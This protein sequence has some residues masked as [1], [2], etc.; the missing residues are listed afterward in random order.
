MSAATPSKLINW[1]LV[2]WVLLDMDGT[3]LDLAYDNWFWREHV[4]AEYAALKGISLEQ[5]RAHLEPQ[6]RA[7]MHTLPWYST[8]YWSGITGL[9]VGGLK[10]SSRERLA[11]L[12]GALQFI[13]AVRAS[14][15]RLWLAT[16]AHYEAWSV[17]LEHTGLRSHFEHIIC[18]HDFGAPKES[19]DFWRAFQA[20]HPFEPARALFVDDSLPVCRAAREFGIGQVVALAHPDS[21]QPHRDVSEFAWAPRLADLAPAI[22]PK[23]GV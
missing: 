22:P 19:Q 21:T 4:P 3:I 14:G 13:E 16:N 15:R 9:D 17:K 23:R 8:Q 2:D 7:V 18:S 12:P 6:F 20:R 11:V 1:D 5:A 10:R